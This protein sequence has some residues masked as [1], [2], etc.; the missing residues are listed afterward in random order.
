[1][2][3][4]K[5]TQPDDQ[6][7]IRLE[8]W[9]A[10]DQ[11]DL[12]QV[13][14]LLDQHT[15]DLN[16]YYKKKTFLTAAINKNNLAIV[17]ALI[18][19]HADVNQHDKSHRTPLYLS[20]ALGQLDIT[21]SLLNA[22]A[23]VNLPNND[24]FGS[25]PLLAAASR[26]HDEIIDL[27]IQAGADVNE[28]NLRESTPLELA[29]TNKHER[30]AEKLIQLGA[31]PDLYQMWLH[32]QF[33]AYMHTQN[34][35]HYDP[36]IVKKLYRRFKAG[37]CAGRTLQWLVTEDD[38]LPVPIA[39]WNKDK[40]T[41]TP[42][43]KNDFEM[44]ST[45]RWLQQHDH[46]MP[47]FNHTTLANTLNFV[48]ENN[49]HVETTFRFGFVMTGH[50]LIMTLKKILRDNQ[51]IYISNT[52]HAVGLKI[53]SNIYHFYNSNRALGVRNSSS[54]EEIA[55]LIHFIF[56]KKMDLSYFAPIC[57]QVLERC[58][59]DDHF[60]YQSIKNDLVDFLVNKRKT[61]GNL[62]L[63]IDQ[64]T[65][66]ALAVRLNDS[67]TFSALIKAGADV[68]LP[69]NFNSPLSMSAYYNHPSLA[70][71]LI[72]KNAYI[73]VDN[74]FPL[75]K[76][77]KQG[78][79]QIVEI[80][81]QHQAN[82]IIE[83]KNKTALSDAAHNGHVEILQLLIHHANFKF[84]AHM[85]AEAVM[86][87]VNG[88]QFLALKYLLS[89]GATPEAATGWKSGMLYMAIKKGDLQT[90]R[91]LVEECHHN[92]IMKDL[93]T[94]YYLELAKNAKG[95]H[96]KA[97]YALLKQ[98]SA[99]L[100]KLKYIEPI[101][102][103]QHAVVLVENKLN[104]ST[105]CSLS[106]TSKNMYRFFKP[107][108][109]M[110]LFKA[111]VK[112]DWPTIN[113]I[114]LKKPSLI[115][116][117]FD[118]DLN[119]ITRRISPLQYA[120]MVFDTTTRRMMFDVVKHDDHLTQLFIEEARVTFQIDVLPLLVMYDAYTRIRNNPYTELSIFA[121]VVSRLSK[122][123]YNLLP[124]HIMRQMANPNMTWSHD[125]SFE[126][127]DISQL[128]NHCCCIEEPH[129]NYFLSLEEAVK[130]MSKGYVLQRNTA[131]T[132]ALFKSEKCIVTFD[133]ILIRCLMAQRE[134][135]YRE[136]MVSLRNGVGLRPA[137]AGLSPTYNP[138]Y[139]L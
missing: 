60:N 25:T 103:L 70:K 48:L 108:V 126:A 93:T 34:K 16:V 35:N 55:S 58:N 10:I 100:S 68:N 2:E 17:K 116:E 104:I 129:K 61:N 8:L 54:I 102:L 53:R 107:R 78:Y 135:E 32:E 86:R 87:A 97:I 132:A 82:P 40:E 81:L 31:K 134:K 73:N 59:R 71:Q 47:E 115:F 75:R 66:L 26:G 90:V 42:Q 44:F 1:M 79:K 84:T 30:T 123:Q 23:I 19:H 85:K 112:A 77:C 7:N 111:V 131:D 67:E 27:L 119:G 138:T 45:I 18:Q 38:S 133:K 130:M 113:E 139:K 98:K 136:D 43:L 125:T 50:E 20:S 74:E 72:E 106:A 83:V 92:L 46:L 56:T 110:F 33:I 137:S 69:N 101:P 118:Y 5:E 29:H 21:R 89:I 37:M 88:R 105:M 14:A 94:D 3:S 99:Y 109:D 28:E 120:C 12:D 128:Q 117:K 13:N 57:M 15:I 96:S 122:M 49:Q 76:A 4:R 62:N 9:N 91:Y 65:S 127:I 6:D 39:T 95:V 41:L 80:L 51:K 24:S 124:R 22:G 11:E 63:I 52:A 64:S 36:A 121:N 114:I